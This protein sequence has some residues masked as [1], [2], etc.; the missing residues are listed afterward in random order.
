MIPPVSGQVSGGI[1][2]QRVLVGC[3]SAGVPLGHGPLFHVTK[4]PT[5]KQA[6]RQGDAGKARRCRQAPKAAAKVAGA[7]SDQRRPPRL[8]VFFGAAEEQHLPKSLYFWCC[9]GWKKRSTQYRIASHR[10]AYHGGTANIGAGWRPDPLRTGA[11]VGP[12]GTALWSR[13]LAFSLGRHGS[14]P[15][16]CVMIVSAGHSESVKVRNTG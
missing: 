1:G 2:P 12:G 7:R 10:S 6:A 13:P 3:D 15:N 9:V 14:F 16:P 4:P 5:A 11:V 8:A